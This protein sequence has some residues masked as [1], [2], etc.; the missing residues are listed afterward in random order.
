[1][2]EDLRI[3]ELKLNA[4]HQLQYLTA[5]K[6]VVINNC[7]TSVILSPTV[8]QSNL[9]APNWVAGSKGLRGITN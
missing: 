4:A 1:M 2:P 5:L 6:N 7:T 9:I 8:Y 3:R